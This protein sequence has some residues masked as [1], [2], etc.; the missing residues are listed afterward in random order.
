M[1]TDR[2]HELDAVLD[3]LVKI[4]MR[5]RRGPRRKHVGRRRRRR[6]T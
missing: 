6:G 3:E 5:W 2:G 4:G 1:L